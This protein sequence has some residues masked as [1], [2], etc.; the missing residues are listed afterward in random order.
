MFLCAQSHS[1]HNPW[2]ESLR[3]YKKQKNCRKILEREKSS[4]YLPHWMFISRQSELCT[5]F[6][7]FLKDMTE[8]EV[9]EGLKPHGVVS[10]YKFQTKINDTV[11]PTGAFL[12]EKIDVVWW[13]LSVRP[14]F[15]NSM[16]CGLYQ[17]LGHTMKHCKNL[18]ICITCNL[19]P[20]VNTECTRTKCAN[21]SGNHPS[22]AAQNVFKPKKYLKS[23]SRQVQHSRSNKKIQSKSSTKLFPSILTVR[24]IYQQHL[25]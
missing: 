20:H 13:K 18:P 23:N 9:V 14:S 22:N 3:S 4:R 16:R 15:P 11:C 1:S 8:S 6:A 7:P 2:W 19:P 10:V 12:P 5:I 17:I 21:C 25:P 24:Q